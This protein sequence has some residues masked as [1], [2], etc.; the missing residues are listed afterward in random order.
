MGWNPLVVDMGDVP[1][2]DIDVTEVAQQADRIQAAAG[3]FL[4][5]AKTLT[6]TWQGLETPYRTSHTQVVIDQMAPAITH[7]TRAEWVYMDLAWTLG[8]FVDELGACQRVGTALRGD[9]GRFLRIPEVQIKAVPVSYTHLTLPT[10]R[11]V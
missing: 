6:E 2:V 5:L 7:A 3:K 8:A 11:I 9:V 1:K 10:K 4:G